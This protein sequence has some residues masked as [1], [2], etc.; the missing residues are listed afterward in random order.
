MNFELNPQQLRRLNI[1][2]DPMALDKTLPQKLSYLAPYQGHLI[3]D[4]EEDALVGD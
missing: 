1:R 4:P 2:I 3:P